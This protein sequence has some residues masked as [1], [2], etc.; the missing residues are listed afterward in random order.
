MLDF[1][2]NKDSKTG[3]ETITT[4]LAGKPLLSTPQ[5]NK[6][7]AFT[8]EERHAF[9]LLGKLPARIE[10]LEEQVQRCYKQYSSYVTPLKRNVFLNELHD[11]NHV[12]F[13]RLLQ[14]HLAEM[15]PTIYTPI[16][17]TAVK[18]FSAE[19]RRPRGLYLSYQER[20]AMDEILDNR[21][22]PEIDLIVVTDGEGVLG[23]GDQGIGGMDI[24]IAKLMVYTLCGGIDPTRTLPILLDVGTNNEALL[25]DPLYLG[26][27]HPRLEGQEYDDFIE[28]FVRSVNKKFPKV[29]LHWEDFGRN[30]ARRNLE[31]YQNTLCTFNDDMQGTG[32]VTL[33]ALLAAVKVNHQS[34]KDQRIVVFGGGTA[35]TG[36]SDQIVDALMREG[37]T[38]EEARAKFW[39]I[40]RAGLL[41][42]DMKDLTP[43][44]YVY[45]RD[46]AELA[47]WTLAHGSV[48]TLADVVH[49]IKPTVL[50]GCSAVAGAF[51]EAIIK[52]MA[53]YQDKPI[54]LALSNPTERAEAQP[55]DIYQWTD[56]RA[57]LA[58][59]SPFDDVTFHGVQVRIAQCNNA[60][61]FPGLGLGLIAVQA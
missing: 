17:G 53:S 9:N 44:Q 1:T 39:M 40:D 37:L 22:N 42:Q 6:G 59:G 58:T 45:A 3:T 33:A 47:D 15:L 21:S 31:R 51:N 38:K 60:F 30:N 13:Y 36:I 14:Q 23:I 7:T 2:V 35:G 16:V 25:N 24:P 5:L 18:E 10:T 46:A 57:L 11:T 54:I 49:H 12:L 41:T 4:S 56:G 61:V 43:F 50:I 32:V 8:Y 27:R 55:V 20:D 34:L 48:V 52:E 29:F 28:K 26:W 19:F